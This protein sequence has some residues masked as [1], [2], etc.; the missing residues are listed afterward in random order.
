MNLWLKLKLLN[1]FYMKI[2]YV[3]LFSVVFVKI[4]DKFIDGLFNRRTKIIKTNENRLKTLGGL[5]KSVVK[6]TVYFVAGVML[7][8]TVG[9]NTS[10]ILTA[11]GIGGLALGF[12]AQSL[13][14]DVIAGFFIIFEDQ[15]QVGDYIETNEVGGFVEEIG[16]R[17]TKLRDF[18]GQLHIIPNGEIKRVTNHSRGNMRAL[19]KVR[20]SY[21]ENIDKVFSILKE[22]CE[23]FRALEYIKEGPDVLGITDFAAEGIEFSI[24]AKTTP[25]M[26]WTAERELRKSIKERFEKEGISF[27]YYKVPLKGA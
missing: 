11:A 15:Y 25:L 19:V 12:G 17:I 2:I 18:G 26:Q 3:I 22:V 9:I 21:E 6:Y 1:T 13:V 23:E 10:S 16:F 5:I 14:K 4:T 27:A 8:D 24:I 20:V 7:L